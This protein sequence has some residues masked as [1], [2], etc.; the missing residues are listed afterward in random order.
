MLSSVLR[1]NSF[2]VCFS[3]SLLSWP[4]KNPQ[5]RITSWFW[6]EACYHACQRN[7]C[8]VTKVS[9]CCFRATTTTQ[10]TH[11]VALTF[12]CTKKMIIYKP[13]FICTKKSSTNYYYSLKLSSGAC[14]SMHFRSPF[15]RLGNVHPCIKARTRSLPYCHK[16][17][18][19]KC[20]LCYCHVP[21]CIVDCITCLFPFFIIN[22]AL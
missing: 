4:V 14:T 17:N 9:Q 7:T 2:L 19:F 1:L 18:P 8:C 21:S 10:N 6:A 16:F 20:Y 5:K 11:C 3:L 15:S 12:L 22:S 13:T